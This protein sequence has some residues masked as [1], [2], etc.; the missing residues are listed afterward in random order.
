[1]RIINRAGYHWCMIT[2][3]SAWLVGCHSL[4]PSPSSPATDHTQ[5]G[6]A[7]VASQMS[8]TAMPVGSG[9]CHVVVCPGVDG[10][11]HEDALVVD[12]GTSNRGP[13]DWTEPQVANYLTPRLTGR[14][15]TVVLSH[16][17]RDHY[18]YITRLFPNGAGVSALYYGNKA[19]QYGAGIQQWIAQVAAAG[20]PVHGEGTVAIG[21]GPMCGAAATD[22]LAVNAVPGNKNASSLVLGLAYSGHR[23]ILPG[24]AT[25]ATEQAVIANFGPDLHVALLEASH[26]GSESEGSNSD[27]WAQATSP[28]NLIVSAGPIG[29]YGHPRCDA[30]ER[31]HHFLLGA[32]AH[33]EN[34]VNAAGAQAFVS[35]RA[36][37]NTEDDGVLT[38]TISQSPFKDVSLQHGSKL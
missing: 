36:L 13:H 11:G 18:S 22:V 29:H 30:L 38:F 16:G 31:Y 27:A 4:K 23:V 35:H 21:P 32:S 6:A 25:G 33:S 12:C 20:V 7:A 9:M 2:V 5:S 19:I 10:D 24:D 1:M 37:Y 14:H 15:V 34:C 26:H 8:I 3:A 28:E 17:D